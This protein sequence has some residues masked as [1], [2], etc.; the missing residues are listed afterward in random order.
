MTDIKGER[1]QVIDGIR[2]LSLVG[3]LM[4]NMLIFQYGIWGKDEIQLYSPSK[5]DSAAYI[6]TKIFIEGSFMPI[7]T[8]LFGFG[9]IKMK[10]SLDRKNLKY[11]RYF[12]RRF[13]F[14][15]VVGSLHSAYLWE[16]DILFFY[17]L[18]GLLLLIFV[19]RKKKTLILLGSI[20]LLLFSLLG[21]GSQQDTLTDPATMEAY[22]K[23]TIT[24]YSTGTY[25]EIKYHRNNVD[26]LHLPDYMYLFLLLF[27]PFFTAPMFLFGMYAAKDN[28]FEEPDKKKRIYLKATIFLTLSG[29]LLK[30]A[31]FFFSQLPWTGIADLLGTSILAFG[32]I[33]AFALLYTLFENSFW[34]K[35]CN[36]VGKLSMSNYL[37]QTVICTTIFYGYGFG[38]FGKLGVLSGIFLSI[39]I[40]ML[41]IIGSY[42]YLKRFKYG[43]VE[44]LLRMW[45]YF[46]F[47]GT[48]TRKKSSI[49][50]SV[51]T[52][53]SQ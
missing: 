10:Q 48:S 52:T 11:K 36:Y 51:V 9:M 28:W 31:H 33:F 12:F 6:F 47:S 50:E 30:S 38:L 4:A 7:F 32:Y 37:L 17:G 27:V 18:M 35:G 43:P 41:Q 22:V 8:F 13:L 2:G 46:S 5:M 14:L 19:G 3:I 26:P 53:Y 23:K 40:F 15:L 29:I 21:Y 25:E 42:W 45:T 20:L 44:K 1:L 39:G 34:V 49:D 24:V 16:G